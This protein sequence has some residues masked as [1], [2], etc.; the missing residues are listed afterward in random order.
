MTELK[1]ILNEDGT[2]VRT[3]QANGVTYKV[4][5]LSEG[6]GVK[7]YSLFRKA[8][9]IL[10]MGATFENLVNNLAQAEKFYNSIATKNPQL[11]DL[12]I[13]LNNMKRGIVESSKERYDFAFWLCTLFIVREGEDLTQ[14]VEADQEEKIK[15]WNAEGINEQDFLALA[16]STLTGFIS[17]YKRFTAQ[18]KEQA[19]TLTDSVATTG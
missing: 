17:T 8:Q 14:W 11:L 16:L 6:I 18:L 3:F 13:I 4:R 1:T 9:A 5:T 10:G 19:H 7:R 15:D 12:G 2:P